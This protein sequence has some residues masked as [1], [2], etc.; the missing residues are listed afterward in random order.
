MH[1]NVQLHIYEDRCETLHSYILKFFHSSLRSKSAGSSCFASN[2]LIC[3]TPVAMV[4]GIVN[5]WKSWGPV[6]QGNKRGTAL[7]AGELLKPMSRMD[8]NVKKRRK[9]KSPDRRRRGG[10]AFG[11]SQERNLFPSPRAPNRP[12]DKSTPP[13]GPRYYDTQDVCICTA[14]KEGYAKYTMLILHLC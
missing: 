14:R 3:I 1:M 9:N 12:G 10:V 4:T 11:T 8:R 13:S 2:S 5:K 7:L 6:E